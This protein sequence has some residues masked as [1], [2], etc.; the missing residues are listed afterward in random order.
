MTLDLKAERLNRGLSLDQLSGEVG[1]AKSTLARM[2]SG[3]TPRPE[4]RLKVAEFYGTGVTDIW[5]LNE[6][7]IA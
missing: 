7:E 2:E 3:V 1:V 4:V 6:K 5:P